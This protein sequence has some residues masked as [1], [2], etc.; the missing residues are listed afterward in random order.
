MRHS[1]YTGIIFIEAGIAV[2]L[3][4]VLALI[5]AG[6]VAVLLVVRTFLEDA[7]LRTELPGYE[8]YAG[9]VRY[10]LLPGIW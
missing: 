10:R 5:P 6:L 4:S 7:A 2:V 9:R 8:E 1:G 3:G